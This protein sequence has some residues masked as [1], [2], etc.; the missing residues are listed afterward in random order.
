V[1]EKLAN[2]RP[3]SR[4]LEGAVAPERDVPT[5]LR[6]AP[7][8]PKAFP[9]ALAAL[10]LLAAGAYG[11]TAV[12]ARSERPASASAKASGPV[13]W[14][15]MQVETLPPGGVVIATVAPGSPGELAGLE[16]GDVI[17]EINNRPVS[18]T[19][20]IAAAIGALRAGDQVLI[21]ISRGSTAYTTHA[22]VAAPPSVHP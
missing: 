15:G 9:I 19:G 21:Q 12:L 11:L 18:A 1:S 14:L 6:R 2:G 3:G 22:T 4:D 17:V 20:D 10:L 8:L 13:R 7:R 16:P 5:P